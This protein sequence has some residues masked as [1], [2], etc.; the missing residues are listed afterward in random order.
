MA[1]TDAE[2][3]AKKA[4]ADA[5]KAAKEAHKK[6]VEALK[7]ISSLGEMQ[8][9][10]DRIA[11]KEGM[12]AKQKD[13]LF[14]KAFNENLAGVKAMLSEGGNIAKLTTGMQKTVIDSYR[15]MGEEVNEG[16]ERRARQTQRDL[17]EIAFQVKKASIAEQLEK[18]KISETNAQLQLAALNTGNFFQ[19]GWLNFQDKMADAADIQNLGSAISQDFSM[20]TSEFQ[21][22][23]ALP[24]MKTISQGIKFIA[25]WLGKWLQGRLLA[26]WAARKAAAK[27][28]GDAGKATAERLRH[29]AG[30]VIDGKKVGGQFMA[31]PAGL[32]AV[33]DTTDTAGL[34]PKGKAPVPIAAAAPA[35]AVAGTAGGAKLGS[36]G[37]MRRMRRTM[38]RMTRA[39]KTVSKA[40]NRLVKIL[41]SIFIGPHIIALAKAPKKFIMVVWGFIVKAM[42]ALIAGFKKAALGLLKVAKRFALVIGSFLAA[43]TAFIVGT[44]LPLIVAF[45]ANPMTWIVIGIIVLL[46]AMAVGLYFL[47]NYIS[48]NWETIKLKMKLAGD[49]LKEIGTKIADWF[50]DLGSDIGFIIKKMVARVKDGFVY[51]VNSVIDGFVSRLPQG[52]EGRIGKRLTALKMTGGYS[53]ALDEG[54]G[55]LL[56]Q[57]NIT[58]PVIEARNAK[59]G[60]EIEQAQILDSERNA[61][62]GAGTGTEINA[63]TITEIDQRQVYNTTESTEITDQVTQAAVA[64]TQ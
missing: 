3:T 18:K 53:D 59:G 45:L 43:V 42:G 60:K 37:L 61:K 4:A 58:N 24:G 50:K 27:G 22:I 64:V 15:M 39:L 52:A 1:D 13:A 56:D 31:K 47:W 16:D 36:K 7:E 57:L 28:L 41:L 48:D 25:A 54:K 12:S 19:K 29:P 26:W 49:R 35:A 2:K 51:I 34:T 17:M 38:K 44:I 10:V 62:K 32:K 46:V 9:E 6:E 63:P 20:L 8:L 40:I 11:L 30:T 14:Q 5:E 21:G 55:D 33:A 23:M